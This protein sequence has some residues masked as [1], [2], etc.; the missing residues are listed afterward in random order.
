MAAA[1]EAILVDETEHERVI[2][3]RLEQLSSVG[4]G[5]ASAIVL[6]A[7]R[8][9]DLHQAARLLRQGCPVDTAVRILL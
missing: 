3:W 4:Y 2:R 6:A 7:N 9:V 8:D 1:V 5:W